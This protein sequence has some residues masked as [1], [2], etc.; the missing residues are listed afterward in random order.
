[1]FSTYRCV[2]AG[3]KII[4]GKLGTEHNQQNLQWFKNKAASLTDE[5][6][7]SAKQNNACTM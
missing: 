7:N 2:T 6:A 1:M 3:K 5:Q 4:N